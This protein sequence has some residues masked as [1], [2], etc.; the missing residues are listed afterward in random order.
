MGRNSQ[1]MRKLPAPALSPPSHTVL[2]RSA[3]TRQ[4]RLHEQS[5]DIGA[6]VVKARVDRPVMVARAD[7]VTRHRL[8]RDKP[9]HLPPRLSAIRLLEHG[10]VQ[11]L[12]SKCV[13]VADAC[14]D[15]NDIGG[16]RGG[17]DAG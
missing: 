17:R 4:F 10:G 12:S 13:T 16:D 15:S 8:T 9:D 3:D 5:S 14:D 11:A 2:S 1:A 7:E 6:T